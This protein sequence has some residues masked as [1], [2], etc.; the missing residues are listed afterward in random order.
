MENFSLPSFEQDIDYKEKFNGFVKKITTK[1]YDII[2]M[3]DATGSMD[4]WIDAAA[5]RCLNISEE[6]KIK[7]PYLEF[8]FGGIFSEILLILIKMSMKYLT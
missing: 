1:E 7:F 4:S 5:D 2:Y 8:Y 3:I 6:L